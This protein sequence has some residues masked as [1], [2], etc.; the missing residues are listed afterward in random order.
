MKKKQMKRARYHKW[1]QEEKDKLEQLRKTYL[2][3]VYPDLASKFAI[4]TLHVTHGIYEDKAEAESVAN[5]FPL[6]AGAKNSA[7][8]IKTVHHGYMKCKRW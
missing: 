6:L 1:T 7:M 4:R 3:D 5:R 2:R 8:V